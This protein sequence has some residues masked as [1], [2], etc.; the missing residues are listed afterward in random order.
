MTHMEHETER[1]MERLMDD[2]RVRRLEEAGE[3]LLR[4]NSDH[5]SEEQLNAWLRWCDASPA[6]VE[7][8]ESLQ[9][10]WRDLDQLRRPRHSH[11]GHSRVGNTRA[12]WA[13]AAGIALATIIAAFIWSTTPWSARELAAARVNKNATLPDGSSLVLSARTVVNVDYTGSRRRLELSPGEAYFK[14]QHDA[15]RPFVVH[16][17]DV[18]V[19]A[20]G[21]AFDV[22]HDED[23]VIV[24]VEEGL[25]EV[26]GAAR[27]G[28]SA[29]NT[30]RAGP[31]YQVAY[32][33]EQRTATIASVN[34][35]T[36]LRWRHGEL[37]YVW[38]PFE[39]VIADVNR[40]S[41]RRLVL[42]D[43]ELAQLHFTGTV[44]TASIDDW[45]RAVA[46]AY[47]I[48]V[49]NSPNGNVILERAHEDGA[50]ANTDAAGADTVR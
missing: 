9:R 23:R 37:A 4:L 38:Q 26:A 15:E 2:A 48:R 47:P 43:P 17:G 14:V 5:P 21:T 28:G 8:F 35:E 11:L 32:S 7:V 25:V 24:T 20:V 44:F 1:D 50:S 46:A 39:S 30:W 33:R 18:T 10:D 13:L 19:T 41:S 49:R 36:V 31:G 16:A 22:R 34:P 6:N 3:W 12:K 42:A 45:L 29:P 40:Y 27:S